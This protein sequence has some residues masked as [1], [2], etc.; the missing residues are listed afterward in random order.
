MGK[1]LD[2]DML[3]LVD[4]NT[5]FYNPINKKLITLE[6][7]EEEV[8]VKIEQY[9]HY[10]ALLGD[11]SDNIEGV[12][13]YGVVKSKRLVSEGYDGICKILS[14]DDKKKLDHNIQMI[15]LLGSYH[16]EE[17]EADCYQKQYEELKPLKADIKSFESKCHEA[18]FYSFLKELSS[19]KESFTRSQTLVDLISKLN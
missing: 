1:K 16:K 4:S 12:D 6:N 8:G 10:K 7:F 3:Q 15:N 9:V 18:E 17:G 13:G 14:D 19:W 5:D 11:K 2:K